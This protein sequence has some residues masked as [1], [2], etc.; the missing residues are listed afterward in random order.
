MRERRSVPAAISVHRA[1]YDAF[2]VAPEAG[3]LSAEWDDDTEAAVTAED[4][5]H[6]AG[7][8]LVATVCDDPADASTLLA[9]LRRWLANEAMNADDLQLAYCVARA[10]TADLPLLLSL[11]ELA[12]LDCGAAMTTSVQFMPMQR[13]NGIAHL[14]P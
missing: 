1:A 3:D 2:Q 8:A 14:D 7:D 5:Y 12:K 9:H 13:S 11:I 4:A 6:A 10:R